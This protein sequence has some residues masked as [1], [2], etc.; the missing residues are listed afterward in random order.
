MHLCSKKNN[1]ILN[2]MQQ[3]RILREKI[4]N[5]LK[6]LPKNIMQAIH[7]VLLRP[8]RA[9]RYYTVSTK[10]NSRFHRRY[11]YQCLLDIHNG[12]KRGDDLSFS[13]CTNIIVECSLNFNIQLVNPLKLR[14]LKTPLIGNRK[15]ISYYTFEY[16]ET[17]FLNKHIQNIF[18]EKQE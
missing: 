9:H 1:G 12:F 14:F 16:K 3:S 11:P 7:N 10:R 15:Q 8:V 18:N 13:V 2:T 6:F 4:V 17:L 5:I